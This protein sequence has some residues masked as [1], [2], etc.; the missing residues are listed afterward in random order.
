[1]ACLQH[2]LRYLSDYLF[3]LSNFAFG[4][5]DTLAAMCPPDCHI[6]VLGNKY[7]CLE[8]NVCLFFVFFLLSCIFSCLPSLEVEKYI[9]FVLFLSDPLPT[10]QK[11]F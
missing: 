5:C 11:G 4:K 9:F 3:S 6:N 7:H 1:M 2:R 10:N 8:N